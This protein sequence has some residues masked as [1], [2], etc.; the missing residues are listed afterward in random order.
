MSADTIYI[1]KL[2]SISITSAFAP[3]NFIM[4]VL[5]VRVNNLKIVALA[6]FFTVFFVNGASL[7]GRLIIHSVIDS[8]SLGSLLSALI[9]VLTFA[10]IVRKVKVLT[11]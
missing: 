5:L 11:V 4:V 2:A 8:G 1:A 10:L 3:A 6:D 9:C 7:C